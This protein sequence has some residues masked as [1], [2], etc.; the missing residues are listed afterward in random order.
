M[1]WERF[2]SFRSGR[3]LVASRALWL[4]AAVVCGASSES[5]SQ[6][7]LE[8]YLKRVGYEPIALERTKA[9]HLVA[10]GQLNRKERTFLV[11]TGCSVTTLQKGIAQGLKTLDEMGVKLEDSFFGRIGSP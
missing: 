5:P 9:N 2:L 8:D 1:Y 10:R 3:P 6:R 11:D 4:S 7:S